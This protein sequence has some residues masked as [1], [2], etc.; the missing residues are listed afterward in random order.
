MIASVAFLAMMLAACTGSSSK[1][2][3]D[4]NAKASTTTAERNNA[5]VITALPIDLSANPWAWPPNANDWPARVF[6]PVHVFGRAYQG[7]VEETLMFDMVK[8]GTPVLS[9]IAGTVV[10]VRAQPESCDA[11]VYIGDERAQQVISLD[12]VTPTVTRGANV[13]SGQVVGTVPKW[14]CTNNFGGVELMVVKDVGGQTQSMCPLQYL[15]TNLRPQVDAQINDVM[16]RWN[17]LAGGAASAYSAADL[18]RGPCEVDSVAA[19]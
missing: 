15:A 14:Q 5:F 8:V 16:V 17:Q 18:A 12:H 4:T 7:K 6:P 11:E 2:A 19:R 1:N 3:A 13:T 9:P 10:D